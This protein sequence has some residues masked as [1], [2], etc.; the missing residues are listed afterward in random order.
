[1]LGVLATFAVALFF[2]DNAVFIKDVEQK[3]SEGYK[4]E[5]TGKHDADPA[6]PH[7]AANGKVYFSMRKE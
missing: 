1:M 3:H 2:N 7:I 5:Y 6:I 4:F